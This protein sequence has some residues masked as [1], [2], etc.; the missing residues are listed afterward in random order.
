[1]IVGKRDFYEADGA[2]GPL[3]AAILGPRPHPAQ[4]LNT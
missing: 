3:R 2:Q 4:G 1:V